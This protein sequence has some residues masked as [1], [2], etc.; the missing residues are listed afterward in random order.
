MNIVDEIKINKD[1]LISVLDKAKENYSDYIKSCIV[2]DGN[3]LGYEKI[4]DI[5]K[6]KF[7]K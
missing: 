4:I 6:N 1:E 7:F 2:P 5:L 3:Q